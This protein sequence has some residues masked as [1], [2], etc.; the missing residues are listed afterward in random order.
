LWKKLTSVLVEVMRTVTK[1]PRFMELALLV[2]FG[3]PVLCE[4]ERLLEGRF[5]Q[6]PPYTLPIGK[7]LL[8]KFFGLLRF[9]KIISIILNDGVIGR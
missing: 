2:G 3:K 8:E 9:D 4:F 6:N 7:V 5:Q 1:P